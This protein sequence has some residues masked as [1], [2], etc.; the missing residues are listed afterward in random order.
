[1]E[2]AA[3]IDLG[4]NT[5]LVHIESRGHQRRLASPPG[6]LSQLPESAV[7]TYLV[8]PHEKKMDRQ[9]ASRREPTIS[10]VINTLNEEYR[11]PFALRSVRGWV[12]EII[13][14]DM[15]SDDRTV[16][17]AQQFGARVFEHER[18]G[19]ADPARAFALEQV[20]CDWVL[21]LDADE[22][23]Q[24]PLSRRLRRIAADDECDVVSI[25]WRNFLL[26]GPLEH[27]GWGPQQDRHRRFFRRGFVSARPDIHD[28]LHTR[29][30]ARVRDLSVESG[31]AIVHF[32]YRDVTQF[33]EKLN[34]Y[35][36]VEAAAAAA[37]GDH[38]GPTRALY[39]AAREFARRYLRR[40]GYRDGWRGFY[41]SAL[42][43]MYRLVVAAKLEESRQN[44]PPEAVDEAYRK[45][46]ERVLAE[47]DGIGDC[48]HP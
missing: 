27:T 19:Y 47:Y 41:L 44:G 30:D 48:D 21:V 9:F 2:R 39:Q 16:A 38:G 15:H 17:V 8:L 14:V 18:V 1:M 6:A 5:S 35:T 23:V 34:R 31:M 3:P 26:G 22:L 37:R 36:T 24:Y 32:N 25:P 12:D 43:A 29:P 46:A 13:V 10:V 4:S 28:Y 20:T 33:V 11:L 42:M 45:V 7:G 40:G